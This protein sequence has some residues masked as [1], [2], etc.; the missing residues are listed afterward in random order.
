MNHEIGTIRY[1]GVQCF[2]VKGSYIKM[3]KV[4]FV[5]GLEGDRKSV[6]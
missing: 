5:L 2:H 4:M 1:L 3:V 6:V